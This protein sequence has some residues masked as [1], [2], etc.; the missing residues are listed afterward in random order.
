M[1]EVENEKSDAA[2]WLDEHVKKGEKLK[3]KR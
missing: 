2:C 1:K 3:K